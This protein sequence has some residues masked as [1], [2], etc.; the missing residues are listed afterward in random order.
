MK[1]YV[2]RKNYHT[3]IQGGATSVQQQYAYSVKISTLGTRRPAGA[4]TVVTVAVEQ[5]ANVWFAAS[6]SRE[7]L[8]YP[9]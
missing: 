4:V 3:S 6:K 9:W 7:L 5:V 2:S 8:N 1:L